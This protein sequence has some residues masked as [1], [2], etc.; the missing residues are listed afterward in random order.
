M[1]KIGGFLERLFSWYEKHPVL[2]TAF[3]F[4]LTLC[5][6]YGFAF[7]AWR[8]F[9]F[10][11]QRYDPYMYAVKGA[12]I[13]RG[14]FLPIST[15]GLGWPALIGAVLWITGIRTPLENLATASVL[16][17]VISAAS[18]FP[19]M[20]IGRCISENA[21]TRVLFLCLFASSFLLT[22]PENDSIA[23]ADPLFVFLFLVSMYFLY[24]ARVRPALLLVSG[25]V[26]AMAYFVKPV[27][28]FTV[29]IAVISY[30]L[31]AR[32]PYQA[33]RGALLFICAF[34]AV[35]TPFLLHRNAA[36]G[37]FFN[38]GENSN[39]FAATY[40]D[41]WGEAVPAVSFSA[42]A[43]QASLGDY[44]NKVFVGGFLFVLA[45]I[46]AAM[47]PYFFGF[48]DYIGSNSRASLSVLYPVFIACCIWI[49]GLTPVFHI[50]GNPRHILP[51]IPLCILLG[52]VG[53]ARLAEVSPRRNAAY[54]AV[55]FFSFVFLVVPFL[56]AVF[57]SK[58]KKIVMRDG[59]V[60]ARHIAPLI[61]GVVAIGNGSDVLMAQYPDSSVGGRGM[62]S[63][64]A[65]ASGISIRY[66]GKF[67]SVED[68][69]SW[70]K[71]A[72]ISYVIFDDAV[73]ESFPFA[74]DKY[75]SI[76]T[77][78]DFPPYLVPFYSNYESN[79]QWKIRV[80]KVNTALL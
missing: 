39:Y 56:I 34:A 17:V 77:G 60:W 5:V 66:P 64:H 54:I 10:P 18:I 1:G 2:V 19:F 22:L 26:A 32:T 12:E 45:M 50:Y 9:G 55:I 46:L 20:Y 42:Y 44:V 70:L 25:A 11:F 41:A 47:T 7:G 69:R 52:G 74:P 13:A 71:A 53:L 43:A 72:G 73:K 30:A 76:Y 68:F 38:Y 37:S 49:I 67:D 75:L 79:S 4:F 59:A 33:V 16:A 31:W 3:F 51:I 35:A 27:G 28:L 61:K 14:D 8:F 40:T 29:P 63:M 23:M 65:P 21:R 48:L 36:F 80:F 78:V 15:H 62:L 58:E 24:A 6:R 57:F